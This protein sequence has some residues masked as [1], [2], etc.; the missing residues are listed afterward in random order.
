MCSC[1]F[2]GKGEGG[3]AREVVHLPIIK[4]YVTCTHYQSSAVICYLSILYYSKFN[5]FSII[6][7][8]QNFRRILLIDNISCISWG[9]REVVVSTYPLSSSL[10]LQDPTW[11]YS[12]VS[13]ISYKQ[14]IFRL[15]NISSAHYQSSDLHF[16]ISRLGLFNNISNLIKAEEFFY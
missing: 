3:G 7:L 16:E 5:Y 8:K 13:L 9:N 6:S 14:I 11:D 15:Q 1:V 12:I 10:T 2:R 4:A